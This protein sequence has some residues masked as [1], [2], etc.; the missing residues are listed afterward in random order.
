MSTPDSGAQPPSAPELRGSG[1]PSKEFAGGGKRDASERF[2]TQ[3]GEGARPR[4]IAKLNRLPRRR[5]PQLTKEIARTTFAAPPAH[6]PR[7]RRVAESF[8]PHRQDRARTYRS[9]TGSPSTSER[10]TTR[11][12]LSGQAGSRFDA[13]NVVSIAVDVQNPEAHAVFLVQDPRR[14]ADACLCKC[15]FLGAGGVQLAPA[16]RLPSSCGVAREN[17]STMTP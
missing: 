6:T 8:S 3:L 17:Q 4:R 10:K 13:Q 15:P 2:I 9:S 12:A 5:L 11:P 16:M 14:R 7:C 1:E